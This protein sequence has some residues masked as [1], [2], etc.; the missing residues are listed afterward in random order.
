MS[1]TWTSA[2]YLG[3]GIDVALRLP[4]LDPNREGLVFGGDEGAQQG[5]EAVAE[6][7]LVA[8]PQAPDFADGLEGG[9]GGELGVWGGKGKVSK[10]SE[11]P[12]RSR[13]SSEDERSLVQNSWR[14]ACITENSHRV[15]G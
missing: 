5:K 4:A 11:T 13:V 12:Y 7:A 8:P 6:K 1:E 9:V 2:R 10:Q 14:R 15:I 3:E